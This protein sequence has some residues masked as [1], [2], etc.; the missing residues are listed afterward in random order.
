MVYSVAILPSGVGQ[1]VGII[2]SLSAMPYTGSPARFI[3]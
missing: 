2:S 1:K 3:A